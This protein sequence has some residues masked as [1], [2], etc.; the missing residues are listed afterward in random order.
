MALLTFEGFDSISSASLGLS[1]GWSVGGFGST[2]I[3]GMLGGG[4]A[5]LGDS[6]FSSDVIWTSDSSYTELI[7]GFRYLF[8]TFTSNTSIRFTDSV[9]GLQCG[10]NRSSN[11]LVFYRGSTVLGT[12][13]TF[14]QL[15]TWY[16]IEIRVQAADSAN[17]TIKLDNATEISLTGVDTTNTANE[18]FGGIYWQDNYAALDDVYVCDT[19]GG[20]P[21]NDFLG[22]CR[23]ETL[24][25]TSAVSTMWTP[26]ASTNVSRVQETAYD[27]DTSY[28]YSQSSGDIDMFNHG[29]LSSIPLVIYGAKVVA[30]ARKTDNTVQ[31]FRSKL[32]SG[33]T[34]VNGTTIHP[35]TGYNQNYATVGD[36]VSSDIYVTDPNTSAAWNASAINATE[37]GYEH[38]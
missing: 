18:N 4:A 23:V 3:A 22:P 19:T 5:F 38:I 28:N 24:Y 10:I 1:G 14:I 6:S 37:I 15:N 11:H 27:G 36:P 9:G 35:Q 21:T 32:K 13:T 31:T 30:I 17:V 25:P 26:N 12:G 20:S 29:S 8:S 7:V 34:S 2:K 16:Y 33:T